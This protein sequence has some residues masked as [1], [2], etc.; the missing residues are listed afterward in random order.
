MSPR[1]R[2][3]GHPPARPP[4]PAAAALVAVALMTTVVAGCVST[5][6]GH[7]VAL[8]VV[9]RSLPT[10]GA[11]TTGSPAPRGAAA[12]TAAEALGDLP[13]VDPCSLVDLTAMRELGTVDL[14]ELTGADD[15]P[16][17]V[18][19]D[20]GA[21]YEV[22]IGRL[23]T[24]T[25][26]DLARSEVTS[27]PGGLSMLAQPPVPGRCER[28]VLFADRIAL[29]AVADD[30]GEGDPTLGGAQYCHAA[31]LAVNAA[32]DRI[33]A[34]R[35]AHRQAP[36]GS[37]LTVQ[38]CSLLSDELVATL[39]GIGPHPPT[40]YP[41]GHQCLYGRAD[42][43]AHL[44][45]EL[46]IAPPVLPSTANATTET[47]G[48]RTSVLLRASLPDISLC[49]L[50]ATHRPSADTVAPGLVEFSQI[51]VNLPSADIEGACRA[52]RAAADQ[53][54]PKLPPP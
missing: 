35:V 22:D 10:S 17:A 4:A 47:H 36:A 1:H 45:V 43:T 5:V 23:D 34:E 16:V 46:G 53:A 21:H 18:R 31:E 15:C 7:P 30:L 26:A 54:W 20:G 13:T 39:P 12:P 32:A 40:P 11:P 29:Q 27:L 41:A 3:G 2:T 33:A 24:V 38:A 6:G 28:D 25:P 42:R 48:G 37:L 9:D 14:A 8:P 49:V 51:V 52:A 44:R 50:S 19:A